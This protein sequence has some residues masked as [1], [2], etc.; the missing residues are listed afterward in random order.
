MPTG[1]ADGTSAFQYLVPACPAWRLPLFSRQHPCHV[2]PRAGAAPPWPADGRV[3]WRYLIQTCEFGGWNRSRNRPG[4][5][6]GS[7]AEQRNGQAHHE[8][9]IQPDQRMHMRHQREGDG[10]RNQRE[11]HG[12]S[13]QYIGLGFGKSFDAPWV[14]S[15]KAIAPPAHGPAKN[16]EFESGYDDCLRV[17]GNWGADELP[18]KRPDCLKRSTI[19]P[20][21]SSGADCLPNA[22]E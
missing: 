17:T 13:A 9:G 10:L 4:D 21:G 2:L 22:R 19:I 14:R 8:G 18:R 1:N 11:R 7:S 3:P 15:G 12:Q 5:H 20:H 16:S 6:A